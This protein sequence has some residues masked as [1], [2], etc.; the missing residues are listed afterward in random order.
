VPAHDCYL[1]ATLA[2]CVAIWGNMSDRLSNLSIID[3]YFAIL[4]PGL[5][6]IVCV[7]IVLFPPPIFLIRNSAVL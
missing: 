6:C 1:C 7:E 5:R 2:T 3:H 4:Y